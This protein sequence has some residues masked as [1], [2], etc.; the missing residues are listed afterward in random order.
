MRFDRAQKISM[1][2]EHIED[3]LTLNELTNKYGIRLEDLKYYLALYKKHGEN[4]FKDEIQ[5]YSRNFKLASIKRVKNGESIRGVSIDLGLKTPDVLRDW[6]RKY[7]KDGESAIQD[8]FSRSHY[9]LHE[10]R[11]DKIMN[12][13]FELLE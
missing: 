6:C 12:A 1:I 4:V 8:T 13:L 7:E 2:K 9:L 3:G 11:L 10:D 5:V